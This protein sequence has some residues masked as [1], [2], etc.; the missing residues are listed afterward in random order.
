MVA[1]VA[2]W[3]VFVGGLF[4]IFVWLLFG[5]QHDPNLIRGWIRGWRETRRRRLELALR[6]RNDGSLSQDARR[7]WARVI[8]AAARR[9]RRQDRRRRPSAEDPKA[10]LLWRAWWL[11]CLVTRRALAE[12]AAP[13]RP[14]AEGPG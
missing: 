13:A 2:E 10:D 6:S 1:K 5:I 3:I 9:Q 7:T 12:I 8:R 14:V 11:H 4:G